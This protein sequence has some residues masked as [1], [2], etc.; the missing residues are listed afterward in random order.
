LLFIYSCSKDNIENQK[1]EVGNTENELKISIFSTDIFG[2]YEA[3]VPLTDANYILLYL[4]AWESGKYS[5]KTPEINGY[6]FYLG[7]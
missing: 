7:R 6:R 4:I 3:G 1:E 5:I 2:V